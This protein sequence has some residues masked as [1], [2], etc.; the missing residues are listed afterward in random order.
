MLSQEDLEARHPCAAGAEHG[1]CEQP[2]GSY[3]HLSR[4]GPATLESHHTLGSGKAPGTPRV[5]AAQVSP[6]VFST[7]SDRS[8]HL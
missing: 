7:A 6:A 1:P 3:A 4:P 5:V 8:S 2:L